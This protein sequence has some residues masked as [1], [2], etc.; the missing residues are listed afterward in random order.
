MS[1][2]YNYYIGYKRD[3]KIYP[4]GPFTGNGELFPALTRSASFASDLHDDFY[5]VKD[6]EMTEE[7]K[8]HFSYEVGEDEIEFERVKYL[9]VKELPTGSY[10]RKG[11]FLIKDVEEY[12]SDDEPGWFD[13]FYDNLTPQ[14]YAAK[15]EKQ[16][17]FGPNKPKKNEYGELYTEHDASDYMYYAYPNYESKEYES[18]LLRKFADVLHDYDLG[19]DVE[20]V[21]LETEG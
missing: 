1:Y 4:W 21:I 12:E 20:Y 19:K 13:G 15:L 17:K 10:I 11:Y 8:K 9:P 6:E 7:L 5:D 18:W 2:Y 3:G 14:V 16:L